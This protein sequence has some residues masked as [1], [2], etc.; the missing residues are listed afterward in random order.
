M[1]QFVLGTNVVT[2]SDS[3]PISDR[4]IADMQQDLANIPFEVIAVLSDTEVAIGTEGT[5]TQCQTWIAWE[6]QEPQRP[7]VPFELWIIKP[8]TAFHVL[9]DFGFGYEISMGIVTID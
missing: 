3:R 6:S 2:V 4:C 9:L 1:S 5:L 7:E 8:R